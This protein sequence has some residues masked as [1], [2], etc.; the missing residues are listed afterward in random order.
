MSVAA[1]NTPDEDIQEFDDQPEFLNASALHKLA[2]EYHEACRTRGE[3]NRRNRQGEPLAELADKNTEGPE[4]ILINDRAYP[5]GYCDAVSGRSVV[6]KAPRSLEELKDM[7]WA[8]HYHDLVMV[9]NDGEEELAI[10]LTSFE[11]FKKYHKAYERREFPLV[12]LMNVEKEKLTGDLLKPN[13]YNS[14]PDVEVRRMHGEGW[15]ADRYIALELCK[16][17]GSTRNELLRK[18]YAAINPITIELPQQGAAKIE[19]S[20]QDAAKDEMRARRLPNGVRKYL[21]KQKATGQGLTSE[22]SALLRKYY[23]DY[24]R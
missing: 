23:R 13:I 3:I 7:V 22:A 18:A 9:L 4:G 21:R 14:R 6:Y 2:V 15:A 20:Q 17:F 10:R 1:V 5:H 12:S 8:R 16:A 19:P 11:Q 24:P